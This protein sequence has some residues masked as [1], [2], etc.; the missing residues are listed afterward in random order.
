MIWGSQLTGFYSAG[1]DDHK[2]LINYQALSIW[3]WSKGFEFY[4]W[5]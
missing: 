2:G 1:G 4:G 3:K 5:G